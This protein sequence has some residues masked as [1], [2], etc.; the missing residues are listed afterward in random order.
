MH[1]YRLIG[2]GYCCMS[3]NVKYKYLV[4]NNILESNTNM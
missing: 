4:Q 3:E 2:R 1:K